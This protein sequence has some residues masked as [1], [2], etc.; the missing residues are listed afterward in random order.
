[1]CGRSI[2]TVTVSTTHLGQN[3][4]RD[5]TGPR[6]S[7]PSTRVGPTSFVP[8]G[9]S[10]GT[11][12]VL[13][14]SRDEFEGH[15]GFRVTKSPRRLMD[16]RE[17]L[18]EALRR[19]GRG[20]LLAAVLLL[21]LG[22]SAAV[23]VRSN[24][25]NDT[26]A[27]VRKSEL[28]TVINRLSLASQRADNEIAQLKQKRN[29]YLNDREALHTAVRRAEEQADQYGILSGT[30]PATGQ[31][32]RVLVEDPAEKELARRLLNAIQELR[33]A[34]AEAIEIND[35]VRVVAQSGIRHLNGALV[36]VDGQR[37]TAPFVIEAIGAP[38]T[39]A[40]ALNIFHGF[41]DDIE[42]DGG[43]VVV[44]QAETIEI[45]SIREPAAPEYAEQA[46][47]E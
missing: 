14:S 1:M 4:K 26:Y 10:S 46:P 13:E 5:H 39:L 44:S 11:L 18:R 9:D 38:H 32:V 27:G 16:G 41:V 3:H 31:G 25:Q 12:S 33:D 43:R 30:V 21:V 47:A 23:Q 7:T 29:S 35:S 17:R 36:E 2:R 34:G 28:L 15:G 20:Q 22:F 19:P 24:N 40:S 42:G 6:A 45:G 37:V 8:G